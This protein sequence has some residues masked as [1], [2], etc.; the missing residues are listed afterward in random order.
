[1]NKNLP[2]SGAEG[3]SSDLPKPRKRP[4]QSRSRALVEAIEQACVRI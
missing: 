3:L 4:N 1:M 2:L